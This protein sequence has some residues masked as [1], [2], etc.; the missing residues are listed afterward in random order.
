[1][2]KLLIAS[3]ALA[4]VAGTA[5]AQSSVTVY[6]ILDLNYTTLDSDAAGSGKATSQSKDSL[7]TSRV[8]LK[9]T[10]DLGGGLKAE[11]QL[12]GTLDINA[13]SLG[14]A[15]TNTFDRE[16]W[17]GLSD[18]KLGSVR[19]GRTDVTFAQSIDNTVSQAADLGKT[20]GD[21]GVDKQQVVR[22]S[23]PTI[24]GFTA[25]V[26]YS[27]GASSTTY[28]SDATSGTYAGTGNVS[29]AAVKYVAGNLGLY[30]GQTETKVSATYDRKDTVFGATYNFGVASVGVAQRTLDAMD[31]PGGTDAAFGKLKQTV[32][33][34]AA[35]VSILGAGVKAHAIY[36]KTNSA[37]GD[38]TVTTAA[39]DA[40]GVADS[41]K[42]TL[43]LTK[44]FS[45][46]T[47]GYA[48]LVE[49]NFDASSKAD[50]SAYVVGINHSF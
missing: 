30:A 38:R 1:M 8:G 4:L 40:L 45:K 9:G 44:A 16:S 7:G 2:K 32:V 18:A 41:K 25:E 49:T 12:E 26:G 20:S 3:A 36:H 37:T 50:T 11:F 23:T 19:F 13:G 47:T 34:V 48:A 14:T 28:T 15:G 33:S 10:E 17:V 24:A 35:P 21:Q 31:A 29:S 42:T 22:Y 39:A 27:G 5:Q 46:R 43:A 6:G